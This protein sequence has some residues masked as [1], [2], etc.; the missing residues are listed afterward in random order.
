MNNFITS[1]IGVKISTDPNLRELID[2]FYLTLENEETYNT[3]N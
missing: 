2:N 3:N 1:E